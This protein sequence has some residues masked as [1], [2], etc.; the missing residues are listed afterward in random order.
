MLKVLL[1]SWAAAAQVC[2][3]AAE[4][5]HN[6]DMRLDGENVGLPHTDD[7]NVLNGGGFKILAETTTMNEAR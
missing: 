5:S 6:Y 7:L 1:L 3:V 4:Y 2:R